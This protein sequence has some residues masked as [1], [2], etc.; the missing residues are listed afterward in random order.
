MATWVTHLI[1]ADSVLKEILGLCKH[2]FCVGNIAPDC[3]IE[4]EDWTSFTPS[5]E[6]THWMSGKTKDAADC[7]KFLS[8]YIKKRAI[9]TE[10]E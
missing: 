7:D 10:E 8:D 3:N 5:R 2:E 4:N 1:I 6:I 9:K